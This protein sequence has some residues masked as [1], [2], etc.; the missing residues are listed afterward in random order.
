[1]IHKFTDVVAHI[2][3]W[4][5]SQ[6]TEEMPVLEF[7]FP[8]EE[9]K[10]IAGCK[11]KQEMHPF[12]RAYTGDELK[13][14]RFTLL[15]VQVKFSTKQRRMT[16]TLAQRFEEFDLL[17]NWAKAKELTTGLDEYIE[18]MRHYVEQYDAKQPTTR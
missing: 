12:E 17:F 11:I 1:M 8:T 16:P 10:F 6:G 14:D 15:G 3:H 4:F 18:V 9:A 7:V 5:R 2:R 13:Y